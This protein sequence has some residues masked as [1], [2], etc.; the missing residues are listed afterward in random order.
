MFIFS[1]TVM[2]AVSNTLTTTLYSRAE[3]AAV[4]GLRYEGPLA[5]YFLV[6]LIRCD[7]VDHRFV[8]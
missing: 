8:I 4:D 2:Q 5:I 7:M 6:R 1:F 3:M